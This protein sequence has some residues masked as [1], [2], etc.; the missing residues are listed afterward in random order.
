MG[1]DFPQTRQ[2]PVG[3]MSF[4]WASGLNGSCGASLQFDIGVPRRTT[5]ARA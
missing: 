1:D 2:F 3:S 5:Q 4:E